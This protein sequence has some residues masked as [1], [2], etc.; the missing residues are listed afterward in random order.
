MI[1]KINNITDSN[2][3]KFQ[4]LFVG[5]S[6]PSG[7]LSQIVHYGFA[8]VGGEVMVGEKLVEEGRLVF[9]DRNV[10]ENIIATIL[11]G[12]SPSIGHEFDTDDP[13]LG[14]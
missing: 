9:A 4:R 7:K 3:I 10:L 14:R 5:I 2:S 6:E 8:G 1:P 12:L 11:H 13:K